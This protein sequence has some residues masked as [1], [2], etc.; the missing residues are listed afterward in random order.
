MVKLQTYLERI[1]SSNTVEEKL[2]FAR[3]TLDEVKKIKDPRDKKETLVRIIREL[4]K[5][6][7]FLPLYQLDFDLANNI[8]HAAERRYAIFDIVKELPKIEDFIP[9]YLQAIRLAIEATNEI[10]DPKHRKSILCRFAYELPHVPDV[11][12]S[13]QIYKQA[14][15]QAV[16]AASMIRNAFIRKYSLVDIANE[17]PE[18]DEF[19]PL[20]LYALRLAM[21]LA[22]GPHYR[23]YSLVEIAKELPKSSD[24]AFYR[25]YSLLG[26]A[27]TLP[28]TGEFLKLY[29]DAIKL[30]IAATDCL[31]EPHYQR[32]AL[33]YIAKELPQTEEFIQL[34][35]QVMMLAYESSFKIKDPLVKKHAMIEILRE[36]PKTEEFFPL[37][38]KIIEQV[39][40]FFTAKKRIE[41][42][43]MVDVID[44]LLVAEEKRMKE[45]KKNRYTKDK[46]ANI[47]ARELI[48]FGFQLKDIRFIEILRPYTHVWIQPKELRVAVKKIVD[49]LEKLKDTYHGREVERP[50]LVG[51]EFV[52]TEKQIE[53]KRQAE[54]VEECLSIDLG[55]TNTVIMRKRKGYQP[56]FV[57]LE[58]ISGNYGGVNIIPTTISPK[59]NAIGMEAKDVESVV[60]FKKMLLEGSAEGKRFMEAYFNE[61]YRHL[62]NELKRP[63]WFSIF[64][65]ARKK[66]KLYV[67]V[68]VGFHDYRRDIESIISK[69][70]KGTDVELLEEPLVAAIGYQVA[71]AKDKIVMVID[72]GGCTLD[73]MMLRLNL[74][75]VHVISK[76]DRSKVLGGHDIDVWLADYLLDKIEKT[77]T[78]NNREL[79]SK[80]EEIKIALSD[81]VKVPFC[82]NG[83]NI[84]DVT[85]EDFEEVLAKHNFYRMVDRAILSVL[86]K[87]EKIAVT[88]DKIEAVL[89]T[90]GSSQIQSFKD[91]MSSIFPELMEQNVIYDH[92]PLSAV[93]VGAALYSTRNIIDKHLRLAYALRYTT[94][95]R[96]LPYAYE[97]VFEKGEL[98]P[99]E[100]TYK[101]SPA[102]TLG[103]QNE[104]YLELV[105]VPDNHILRRWEN[106]AGIELIK[107][108][109]KYTEDMAL[110]GFRIVTL[111]FQKQLK[112]DVYVTFCVDD[113]RH[114]KVRYGNNDEIETGIR[115]Q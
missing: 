115:L 100:K 12:E 94:K 46:Y 81:S 32:Y 6:Q 48:K 106:E 64:S 8:E 62:K 51:H 60:N 35:T 58:S 112:E 79:I 98:F 101:L 27:K 57:I 63:Q 28:K 66:E 82:W 77:S 71:E 97:I 89:L 53:I 18:T 90:G 30:A 68:P 72:F 25:K 102:R 40:S 111:S 29:K 91:K 7:A 56:E 20:R 59:T 23:K 86:K 83:N 88:K 75:E 70:M 54:R 16:E 14:L 43:G 5:T 9:L 93:A 67:T 87:A 104:I 3:Q 37:L 15:E 52:E 39:L 69:T 105:E 84:C 17:L 2:S 4:P 114:L 85:R 74:D 103:D 47:L 80:A 110:K 109:L 108:T 1:N 45:S 92:S 13:A 10:E 76:P 49:H 26:I 95:K 36:L 31:N 33:V 38:T 11:P 78:I 34:Y 41:D 65:G 22:E 99:F 21:D 44:Y 19:T 96:D 113:A 107:Q 61:L 50:V 55:A 24:Y 42:V 73:V